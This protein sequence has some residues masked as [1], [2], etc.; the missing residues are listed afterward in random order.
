MFECVRTREMAGRWTVHRA[1]RPIVP[2]ALLL[3]AMAGA[4]VLEGVVTHVSDGDTLRVR[5]EGRGLFAD[6]DAMQPRV[7]RRRFGAC[8]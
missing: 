3:P 7:F 5:I 2:A 8:S 6:R 1:V 4:E